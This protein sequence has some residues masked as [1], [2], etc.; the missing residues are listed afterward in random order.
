MVVLICEIISFHN[1]KWHRD[2]TQFCLPAIHSFFFSA[3]LFGLLYKEIWVSL[4][5]LSH[6]W[7][8]SAWEEN[9][10]WQRKTSIWL[11]VLLPLGN[12]L[13]FHWLSQF[14]YK[15]K[16]TK[17]IHNK[18]CCKYWKYCIHKPGRLPDTFPNS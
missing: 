16:V 18:G 2:K 8:Q 6:V 10:H 3:V 5:L 9:C 7:Q 11:R 1:A 17:P 15:W 12:H 14:I 13:T 4:L